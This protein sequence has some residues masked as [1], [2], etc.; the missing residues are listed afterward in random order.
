MLI[1]P[2]DRF[3]YHLPLSILPAFLLWIIL[4]SCSL[5]AYS[6]ATFSLQGTYNSV[7]FYP[8]KEALSQLLEGK[9]RENLIFMLKKQI[10]YMTQ[11]DTLFCGR[12]HQFG[13]IQFLNLG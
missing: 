8:V 6:T 1:S 5:A 10:S 11:P 13:K 2:D 12:T 3:P 9:A 7:P 4:F